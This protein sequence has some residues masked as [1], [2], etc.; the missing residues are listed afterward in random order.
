[1]TIHCSLSRSRLHLKKLPR[2]TAY[3]DLLPARAGTGRVRYTILFS[4]SEQSRLLVVR[5]MRGPEKCN[6]ACV[7]CVTLVETPGIFAVFRAQR[8]PLSVSM[9]MNQCI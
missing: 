2:L 5:A 1:M 4:L 3:A 7:V 6:L 9:E 8:L